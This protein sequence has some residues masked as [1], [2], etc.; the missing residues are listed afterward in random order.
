MTYVWA[1]GAAAIVFIVLDLLWLGVIAKGYYHAELG[2]LLRQPFNMPAAV[3][4]YLMYLGGVLFF[5]MVPAIAAQSLK[6][7]ALYG[8]LLGLLA[9]GTYDLT[10]LA[11]LKNWPLGLSI[12]DMI[13]GGVLTSVCSVAGVAAARVAS[14]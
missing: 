14:S 4:F 9:Y 5:A 1:Y 6:T 12:V 13:W 2:G 7:A 11:T 3:V 8:F 10:N